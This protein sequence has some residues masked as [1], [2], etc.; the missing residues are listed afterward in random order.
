MHCVLNYAYWNYSRIICFLRINMIWICFWVR[1]IYYAVIY[2]TGLV[3]LSLRGC[4]LLTD[5]AMHSVSQMTNLQALTLTSCSQLSDHGLLQLIGIIVL[6][7]LILLHNS[8]ITWFHNNYSHWFLGLS[9]LGVLILDETRVT[10][11][12]LIQYLQRRSSPDNLMHLSLRNVTG[13][14][15]DCSII[16]IRCL[17]LC[18]RK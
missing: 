12:G 14:Y 11:Q 7:N 3:S 2:T 4:G 17:M 15:L 9:K 18:P 8:I 5:T 16:N 13:Q 1:L 10:D 6:S